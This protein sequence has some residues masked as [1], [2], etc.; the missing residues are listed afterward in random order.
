MATTRKTV[1]EI[2][3]LA[4]VSIATVSRVSRGIG[5]VSPK[6]RERVLETITTHGYRASHLGRALAEQR[7][8]ALGLVFPGLSGPY[9]AELIQGFESEAVESRT[10]VHIVC[11]HERRDADEQ[12]LEMSHRVDGV[13]VLGGT[14]SDEALHRLAAS[15][16]VVVI[17]GKAPPGIPSVVVDNRSATESLTRHLIDRHRLHRLAFVGTP[18]GSPDVTERW[19]GFR[20]AHRRA[21]IPAPR[22]SVRVAMQQHDGVVAMDRMV[23]VGEL[24]E[25]AVCANDELA[26]GVLVGALARGIRVP[27][28]LAITGFDGVPMAQ[29]VSPTLT[30]V[31]QPI[32]EL[33]ATAA[34]TLLQ[35]G[36]G[37]PV[38]VSPIVLPTRISLQ[39]SCGCAA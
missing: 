9:F 15:V 31:H 5:Q 35:A 29:L 39:G 3:E 6:T 38:P 2:A 27:D 4:G 22:T 10:G 8:G 28:D 37:Q 14:V 33:A 16:A 19:Q 21:G 12:V 11:T 25:A 7:H 34:R 13:A 36:A 24:P 20:A 17:A 30:T 18:T 26:L 32:R 1:R 23:S